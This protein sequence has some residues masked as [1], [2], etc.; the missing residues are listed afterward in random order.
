MSQILRYVHLTG[1]DLS[2]ITGKYAVSLSKIL[3]DRWQSEVDDL[4]KYW[5]SHGRPDEI[6]KAPQDSP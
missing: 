3:L 1:Y 6:E 4:L 5:M 2:L